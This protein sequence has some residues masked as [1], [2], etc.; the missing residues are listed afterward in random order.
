MQWDRSSHSARN[1]VLSARYVNTAVSLEPKIIYQERRKEW[2]TLQFGRLTQQLTIFLFSYL[3][4]QQPLRRLIF[5]NLN[6]HINSLHHYSGW[7]NRHVI[8]TEA[9]AEAAIRSILFNLNSTETTCRIITC[10]DYCPGDSTITAQG[11]LMLIAKNLASL[12]AIHTLRSRISFFHM[13]CLAGLI[14]PFT[15]GKCA[16]CRKCQSTSTGYSKQSL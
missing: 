11:F 8:S 2:V 6:R 5:H 15:H 7:A 4:A 14:R 13:R 9:T 3:A 12:A 10:T 16:S 1:L